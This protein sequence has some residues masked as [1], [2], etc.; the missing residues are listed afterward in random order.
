MIYVMVF[1]VMYL[2][3][4]FLLLE[5]ILRMKECKVEDEIF[6]YIK[7]LFVFELLNFFWSVKFYVLCVILVI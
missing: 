7:I 3:V 4:L 2:G 6:M 1:N 5:G